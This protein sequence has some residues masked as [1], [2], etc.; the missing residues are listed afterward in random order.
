MSNSD[1]ID[2][3]YLPAY[4]VLE[5]AYYLRLPRSTVRSWIGKQKGFEPLIVPAQQE[6]FVNLSFINLVEIYVLA[7][8]RREHKLSMPKVR[9]GLNFISKKFPSDNPLAEKDFETDGLT[10]FLNEA[11][12]TYDTSSGQM[13]LADIVKQYMQRI[14]RDDQG[15]PTLLY[16]F[17]REGKPNE[18]K[19]ILIDPK[20]SFGRPVLSGTRIPVEIIAE[21]YRAGESIPELVED[22]E[23]AEEHIKE[24]IRYE[25]WRPAA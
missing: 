24:A 25:L 9:K 23:C 4:N 6:P 12:V 21:R 2:V 3:R 8:I 22:Y 10:F 17:S 16:P 14:G 13:I 7:S 5:A 19:I 18:P 15:N 20:I 1:Q 11:G